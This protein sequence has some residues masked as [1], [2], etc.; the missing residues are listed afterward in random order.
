[1]GLA[2]LTIGARLLPAA[3]VALLSL[4]EV[5]LGPLWVWLAYSERPNTSSL[6]GGAIVAAAVVVQAT[7]REAPLPLPE[8]ARPSC[9]SRAD[10][11]AGRLGAVAR[12]PEPR[13]DLLAVIALDLDRVA[14][15]R[16]TG[17][18]LPLE[19]DGN[20][21]EVAVEAPHHRHGL[22]A[23]AALL[24]EDPRDAVLRERRATRA[25]SPSAL[26]SASRAG[27]HRRRSSRRSRWFDIGR[28]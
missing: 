20:G 12:R 28:S 3:E 26:T 27:G 23:A 15:H 25:A 8:R 16:A 4:L 21:G 18:A 1:M 24:A 13:H 17:A 14:L 11:L 10:Q 22:A 2:L 6:V 5:V 9:P 7:A 19:V